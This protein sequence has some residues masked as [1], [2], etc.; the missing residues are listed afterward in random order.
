[1]TTLFLQPCDHRCDVV[2]VLWSKY[3]GRQQYDFFMISQVISSLCS[4]LWPQW[5]RPRLTNFQLPVHYFTFPQLVN[6]FRSTTQRYPS[7]GFSLK[8]GMT[9]HCRSYVMNV[10]YTSMKNGICCGKIYGTRIDWSNTIF[11]IIIITGLMKLLNIK[12][13]IVTIK[14]RMNETIQTLEQHYKPW[15]CCLI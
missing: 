5:W 10:G 12:K 2:K 4:S 14:L 9:C 7:S 6:A 11:I 8:L 1:M 3:H 13:I 15:F